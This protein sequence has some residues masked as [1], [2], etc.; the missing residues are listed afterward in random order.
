MISQEQ[1]K[2]LLP[3]AC[4]WAEE[5]ERIILDNGVSLTAEQIID[6][7]NAGVCHPEKIRLLQVSSIPLPENP[8][9]R[10][11][12]EETQLIT[13]LTI[14]MAL[15][16]GIFVRSDFWGN[17]GIIIHEFVHTSQYEQLGGFQSFLQKYLYECVTIGYPEA[18]M[19]QEAII[20]AA[21]ICK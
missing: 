5:Q 12:A 10:A 2:I 21:K 3:M 1:F 4:K 14:G 16:Y 18:P 13:P 6:A 11:A 7:K 9:L 8:V 15:R 20:T 17:R 19:E